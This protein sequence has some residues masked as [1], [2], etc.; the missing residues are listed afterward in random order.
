MDDNRRYLGGL[1]KEINLLIII[2]KLIS[3]DLA[4]D[5]STVAKWDIWKGI[6][7]LGNL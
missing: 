3:S 4:S 5:L 2:I 7:G 6:Q 1:F